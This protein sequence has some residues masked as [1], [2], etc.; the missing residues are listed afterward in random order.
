MA[1]RPGDTIVCRDVFR[2]RI[3]FA[4]PLE[5]VRDDGEW[6]VAAIAPGARCQMQSTYRNGHRHRYLDDLV[7]GNWQLEEMRWH[8][9]AFLFLVPRDSWYAFYL[10]FEAESGRFVRW[11][12]NFQEPARRHALGFDTFDLCL[13]LVVHPDRSWQ[14]KDE[15]EFARACELGVIDRN[16]HDEIA[17][18]R[19]NVLQLLE[20]A[21]FPFDETW[22]EWRPAAT[23]ARLELPSH[24]DTLRPRA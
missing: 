12:V 1:F 10:F 2:G 14:W 24:W 3:A 13:D 4:R 20:R 18:A 23:Q 19:Q 16:S 9:H 17:R 8:T 6:L 7:S 21:S 5:V 15:D 22:T 11:Y